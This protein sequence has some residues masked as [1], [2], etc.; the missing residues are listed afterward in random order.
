MVFQCK[1]CKIWF[2]TQTKFNNHK[3]GVLGLSCTM[4]EDT[5]ADNLTKQK[6]NENFNEILSSFDISDDEEDS[7]YQQQS[8]DDVQ[9]DIIS[10]DEISEENER[11]VTNHEDSEIPGLKTPECNEEKA[12]NAE[13]EA[14]NETDGE[15]SR[16]ADVPDS[17]EVQTPHKEEDN[18]VRVE[19]PSIET[20]K[21]VQS[22]RISELTE[23]SI[24]LF[25]DEEEISEKTETSFTKQSESQI[26]ES[27]TLTTDRIWTVCNLHTYAC[28]SF[29]IWLKF[30]F[31][32]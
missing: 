15:I 23:E 1:D 28:T 5:Q 21:S 16:D 24:T 7:P 18:I 29:C 11:S 13:E 19:I 32:F 31:V 14:R 4:A 10:D 3:N 2:R 26:P 20:E 8:S 9:D 25:D 6:T 27:K 30:V 22:P 17:I 12:S